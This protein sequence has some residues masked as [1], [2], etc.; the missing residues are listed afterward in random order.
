MTR[1]LKSVIAESSHPAIPF[2]DDSFV[3]LSYEELLLDEYEVDGTHP[4]YALLQASEYKKLFEQLPTAK[5]KTQIVQMPCL[6]AYKTLKTEFFEQKRL[7]KYIAE[8]TGVYYFPFQ[9]NFV[10]SDEKIFVIYTFNKDKLPWF[11][12][13]FMTPKY[14]NDVPTVA[15]VNLIDQYKSDTTEVRAQIKIWSDYV[16]Y[17]DRMFS[18]TANQTLPYEEKCFIFRYEDMENITND[19]FQLYEKLEDD[20]EHKLYNKFICHF[21]ERARRITILVQRCPTA[22]K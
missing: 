14:I 20:T 1:Y 19:I 21:A 7:K 16:Q 22:V 11:S 9:V 12:R 5:N 8:L 15:D 4:I 13:S 10:R 18:S 2:K 3:S 6:A 17:C